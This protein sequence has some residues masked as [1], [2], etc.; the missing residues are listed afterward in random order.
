MR[1][2]QFTVVFLFIFLCSCTDINDPKRIKSYKIKGLKSTF[3]L[4]ERFENIP[5]TEL[6]SL[7]EKRGAPVNQNQKELI[8][9]R[10]IHFIDYTTED[11]VTI[12]VLPEVLPVEKQFLSAFAS[13]I[14]QEMFKELDFDYSLVQKRFIISKMNNHALKAKFEIIT[15]F[16]KQYYTQ[17]LLTKKNESISV[18]YLSYYD[19]DFQ[20]MIVRYLDRI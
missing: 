5:G 1:F 2:L 20:H 19:Y 17:Y 8:A 11:L 7:F 12:A 3:S 9:N 10:Q 16:G 18:T 4:P 13:I 15:A 14:Q 6:V